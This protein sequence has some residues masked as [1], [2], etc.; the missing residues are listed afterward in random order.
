MI[1]VCLSFVEDW[2][3]VSFVTGSI[4]VGSSS[5]FVFVFIVSLIVS[6]CIWTSNIYPLL[7]GC[8]GGWL[9][10]M[11]NLPVICFATWSTY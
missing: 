6:C 7:F 3:C 5:L 10:R 2:F 8:A 1:C 11:S 4:Y 9:T